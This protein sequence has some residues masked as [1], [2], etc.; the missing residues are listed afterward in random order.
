MIMATIL[1]SH[2]TSESHLAK[3]WKDLVLTAFLGLDP[4][5]VFFSSDLGAFNGQDTFIQQIFDKIRDATCILSLQ[6]P[7]SC[8][9]PWIIFEGGM[10]WANKGRSLY[11]IIYDSKKVEKSESIFG[12]LQNPL[13]G[14]QQYKGLEPSSVLSVLGLIQKDFVKAAA[15]QGSPKVPLI[16]PITLFQALEA[17]LKC[18]AADKEW[19]VNR[20][21]LFERRIELRFGPKQLEAL[22]CSGTISPDVEVVGEAE[23]LAIFT[24]TRA[25][26]WKK[27]TDHLEHLDLPWPQSALKWAKGLGRY[28][29][30]ALTDRLVEDPEGLPLYFDASS[31]RSY[32]PSITSRIEDGNLT[33]FIVSFTHLPPELTV[34]PDSRIGVLFH[35][36]DFARMFRWGVLEDKGIKEFFRKPPA[37]SADVGRIREFVE[38]IFTIRVEFWNRGLK[39]DSLEQVLPKDKRPELKLLLTKYREAIARIDPNDNGELPAPMPTFAVAKEVYEKVYAINRAF[40]KLLSSALMIEVDRLPEIPFS[41]DLDL[42]TE[43]PSVDGSVQRQGASVQNGELAVS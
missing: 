13:N 20:T 25:R 10:A 28:M 9:R 24:L 31:G 12:N 14:L 33:S 26:S 4:D 15:S 34:R 1:I 11:P 37:D 41:D 36:L 3:A 18:V 2:A 39:S 43:V 5:S 17:Y 29:Q 42:S 30:M 35:Y 40:Y 8:K 7:S 38:K 6:T 19:W 32:R 16:N 27:L 22:Q 21:Q 23:S